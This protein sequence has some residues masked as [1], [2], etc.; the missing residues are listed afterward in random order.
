[1]HFPPSIFNIMIHL[2]YHLVD[3]LDLCTP[4][5]T[6]WM[7]L[8]EWYMKTLKTF[9]CNMARPKR[10]M[11]AGYIWDECLSFIIKYLQRFEVMQWC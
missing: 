5:A 7:Y 9:V 11:V 3:E 8:L 1:M 4:V 6:G 2:L 10:S